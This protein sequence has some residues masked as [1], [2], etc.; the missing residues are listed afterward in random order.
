MRP[1]S[2]TNQRCLE[3]ALELTPS[4]RPHSYTDYLGNVVHHFDIPSMHSRTEV[5]ALALVEVYEKGRARPEAS[6]D[7]WTK[8]DALSGDPDYWDWLMPS[9][10]ARPS[11]SVEAFAVE[12]GVRR[13]DD[14]LATL[15]GLKVALNRTIQYDRG[16]THV[17]SPIDECIEKR[18]GVCQDFA[19]LFIA[20]SR[21]LGIPARY[22]SGYLFH[23]EGDP[24]PTARDATHAWAEA[25]IPGAGWVGFDPS[26]MTLT[27]ERHIRVAIGRDYSDVPPNR[28]VFKGPAKE[29][30]HVHVEVERV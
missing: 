10:F 13:G 2:D 23:R 7:A 29:A 19:H 14:P 16:S 27:A 8:L 18:R 24:D 1:R 17:D 26:N 5:T 12:L 4:A 9:P 22:V 28:G 21:G 3:F 30:L 20:I 25:F 15:T 6:P 11:P